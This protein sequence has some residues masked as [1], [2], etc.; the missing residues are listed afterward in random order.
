[1]PNLQATVCRWN[2]Q[3]NWSSVSPLACKVCWSKCR[4][5]GMWGQNNL[6]A[7]RVLPQKHSCHSHWPMCSRSLELATC[8][9]RAHSQPLFLLHTIKGL[10]PS[11]LP[12]NLIVWFSSQIKCFLSP[13]IF[14]HHRISWTATVCRVLFPWSTT[15][16]HHW[17][18]SLLKPLMKRLT[19]FPRKSLKNLKK[20]STKLL[21]TKNPWHPWNP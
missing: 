8:N 17:N 5:K 15:S 12:L 10:P 4:L 18:K 9:T 6:Q 13:D 21:N 11:I 3:T 16:W 14:G 7:P 1:M 20:F 19:K 2:L